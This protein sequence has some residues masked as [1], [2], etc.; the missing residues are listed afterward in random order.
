MIRFYTN[1]E[2]S[3]GLEISLARWKR[4]SREFLDPDPLGGLQSGY[5][6]HYSRDDAF[7]VYLGGYLVGQMKFSVPEARQIFGDLHEWLAQ[8]GFVINHET[9]DKT[10]SFQDKSSLYWIFIGRATGR[11]TKTPGPFF[12]TVRRVLEDGPAKYHGMAARQQFYTEKTLAL[13]YRRADLDP[14]SIRLLPISALYSIYL[15][16]LEHIK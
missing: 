2:L 8:S 6:R 12:Y 11:P 7:T 16:K 15:K 14:V 10:D 1:R 3:L 4:W 5:A 9:V 13:S